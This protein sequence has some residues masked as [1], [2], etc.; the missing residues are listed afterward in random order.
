MEEMFANKSVLKIKQALTRLK[1]LD[2][3]IV[4]IIME[5]SSFCSIFGIS[6]WPPVVT[7]LISDILGNS[8]V[9]ET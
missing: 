1:K 5:L 2:P 3:K 4:T 9:G 6:P 7:G 8:A